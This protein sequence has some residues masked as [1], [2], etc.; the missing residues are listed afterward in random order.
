[1][2]PGYTLS[3]RKSTR[4]RWGASATWTVRDSSGTPIARGSG[5][6]AS[7]MRKTVVSMSCGVGSSK[8]RAVRQPA[9]FAAS[10]TVSTS[11]TLEG[12]A[13]LQIKPLRFSARVG[14]THG[15]AQGSEPEAAT[16]AGMPPTVAG[17]VEPD[18]SRVSEREEPEL[19]SHDEVHCAN[20]NAKLRAPVDG[21]VSRK[22]MI[23]VT[24]DRA[25]AAN[26][27]RELHGKPTRRQ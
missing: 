27:G 23:A 5:S 7:P 15:P 6:P 8:D 18:A 16:D 10:Q 26:R 2:P 3:P 21:P 24:A 9:A 20:R 12:Q 13:T 1:M 11:T 14:D 19:R 25:L 22:S 17:A 4:L